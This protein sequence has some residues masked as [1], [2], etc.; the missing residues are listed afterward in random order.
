MGWSSNFLCANYA[1][2]C[3]IIQVGVL[4][5]YHI[6]EVAFDWNMTHILA[7]SSIITA[8]HVLCYCCSHFL[9]YSPI[10]SDFSLPPCALQS[11]L[12]AKVWN[13]F[14]WKELA[15][16]TCGG[17][18]EHKILERKGNLR[19]IW[20]SIICWKETWV[21]SDLLWYAELIKVAELHHELM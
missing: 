17:G 14:W 1:I 5:I 20:C 9:M 4:L 2:T 7:S 13:K 18:L 3:L 16:L 21:P 10:Y 12:G 11:F 8:I 15:L 6:I 19:S